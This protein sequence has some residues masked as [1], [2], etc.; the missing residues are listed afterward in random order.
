MDHSL[1]VVLMITLLLLVC[2]Y[3]N[4]WSIGY[5]VHWNR[6]MLPFDTVYVINLE[7]NVDRLKEFM[8]TYNSSGMGHVPIQRINAIDGTKI[9]HRSRWLS[10]SANKEMLRSD[11]T[12]HRVNHYEL[13]NGAIGCYMSHALIWRDVLKK[14]KRNALIFEDDAVLLND[15]HTSMC[16]AMRHVPADWDIVLLHNQ[17]VAGF[18]TYHSRHGRYDKVNR[19]YGTFCYMISYDCIVKLRKSKKIFPIS[20]QIDSMLSDQSAYLNIYTVNEVMVKH[21]TTFQT[22]IQIPVKK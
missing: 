10:R 2:N 14:N 17:N 22:D 4:Y 5:M 9:Q 18:M 15:F 20:Q 13:S 16:A 3:S 21:G 11:H 12:G 6:S 8:I 1:C 19:F 7:K